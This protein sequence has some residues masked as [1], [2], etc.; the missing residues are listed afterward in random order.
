MWSTSELSNSLAATGRRSVTDTRSP[1]IPD[2]AARQFAMR[3]SSVRTG[4]GSSPR[5]HAPT[6]VSTSSA[7]QRRQQ[8]GVL[9]GATR[10]R[11]ADL[12]RR[13]LRGESSLEVDHAGV[14]EHAAGD[15]RVHG[16]VV[17]FGATEDVGGARRRPSTPRRERDSCR[18]RCP[19]PARTGELTDSASSGASQG[20]IR[21]S[22]ATASSREA[23]RRRE[24]GSHTSAALGRSV[25]TPRSSP[26]SGRLWSSSDGLA[27]DSSPMDR[28][29]TPSSWRRRR[30]HDVG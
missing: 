12:Q 9:G 26:D 13:V 7:T 14:E 5:C 3:S 19:L 23:R 24:H 1:S 22:A 17:L 21:S 4:S 16:V 20:R 18:S 6:A 28:S 25:R 27:A 11:G 2:R 10:V 15:E 8:G 29:R 30:G